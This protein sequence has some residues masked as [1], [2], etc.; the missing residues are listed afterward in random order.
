MNATTDAI[1][2]AGT[3]PSLRRMPSCWDSVGWRICNCRPSSPTQRSPPAS[4]ASSR[5]R[6]SFASSFSTRTALAARRRMSAPA[7]P[8]GFGV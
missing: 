3:A 1:R 6:S 2:R 5:T 4:W 7:A 8:V